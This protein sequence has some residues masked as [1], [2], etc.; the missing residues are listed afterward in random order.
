MLC[1][2]EDDDTTNVKATKKITDV[3]IQSVTCITEGTRK[4]YCS[5]I[6]VNKDYTKDYV[7]YSFYPLCI[8]IF[9]DCDS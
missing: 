2:D 9:W 4:Y 7:D 8:C 5:K 6:R 3:I 1:K